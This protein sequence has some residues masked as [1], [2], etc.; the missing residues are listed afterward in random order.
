[1]TAGDVEIRL[2][3]EGEEAAVTQLAQDAFDD[4]DRRLGSTETPPKFP[5]R[6]ARRVKRWL[7]HAEPP[8]PARAV[9]RR[10]G[11]YQHL[12][13]T[14]P[15]GSWVAVRGGAVV[16]S[17]VALV[18]DGVWALSLLAVA[19]DM[20]GT[21]VGA[22]LMQ[23]ALDYA[24]GTRGALILSSLDSQAV[25]VYT[26]AGFA[27]EPCL[28]AAGEPRRDRLPDAPDVRVG[29]KG[30]LSLCAA[31]SR[32]VRGATHDPDLRWLLDTGSGLLVVEGR[33]YAVWFEE[34]LELLAARDE[35]A[36]RQLLSAV[37]QRVPP[38]KPAGKPVRVEHLSARQQWAIATCVDL[39]LE[40]QPTG[41]ICWRGAVGPL[42]PYLPTGAFL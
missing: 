13:S 30:D 37:L 17:S 20:Q 7:G 15:D 14:D 28:R 27:V 6:V 36:A 10:V 39:G 35:D 8:E 42:T 3:R 31:V 25:R 26:R 18:R 16:G 34:C 9:A 2:M 32:E 19:P 23:S 29:D 4:L 38:G 21:G 22:A 24:N 40:L 41:P 11:R 33:G 5:R 12:R 1:L